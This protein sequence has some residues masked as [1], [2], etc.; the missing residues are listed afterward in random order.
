MFWSWLGFWRLTPLSTLF[1]LYRG[2]QFYWWRTPDKTIDLSQL[3]AKLSCIE[4]TSPWDGFELAPLVTLCT[5]CISSCK[6]NYHLIIITTAHVIRI[7]TLSAMNI[8]ILEIYVSFYIIHINI[9]IHTLFTSQTLLDASVICRVSC[10][11]CQSL[12]YYN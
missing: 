4:F 5:D 9:L 8:H 7:C 12:T 1:Q 6:S 11:K 2:G 3:T 10:N